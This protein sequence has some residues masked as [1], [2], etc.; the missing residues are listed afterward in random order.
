[1]RRRKE[2]ES[3]SLDVRFYFGCHRMGVPRYGG[4]VSVSRQMM[5]QVG[6]ALA[7]LVVLVFIAAARSY[8]KD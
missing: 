2:D 8:W 1:M 7:L 5:N 3:Y 6:M 4:Y